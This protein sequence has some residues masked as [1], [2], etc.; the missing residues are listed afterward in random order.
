M[1]TLT[2]MYRTKSEAKDAIKKG[3]LIQV[4][5]SKGQVRDNL[6][7]GPI[8]VHGKLDHYKEWQG[9]VIVENGKVAR[10]K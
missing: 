10:L 9:E 6:N 8:T 3:E 2:K 4:V 5:D 1:Q 7:G